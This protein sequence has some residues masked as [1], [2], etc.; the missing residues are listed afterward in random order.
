M[1][2]LKLVV[3]NELGKISMN[4]EELQQALEL[5]LSEYKGIIFTEDSLDIAKKERASLNTLKKDL[6]DRRIAVKK[7]F[8]KPIDDFESNVKKLSIM[9]DEPINQIDKQLDIFEQKRVT[10]KKNEIQSTYNFII[11]EMS[12]FLP[13]EKIYNP[14]WEN[15]TYKLKKIEEEVKSVVVSTV[16]AIETITAMA[17]DCLVQ[18]IEKYKSS[19]NLIDTINFINAYEKQKQ[20]ILIREREKEIER[21]KADERK[22][23]EEENKIR[24]SERIKVTKEVEVAATEKV[25]ESFTP[26]IVDGEVSERYNYVIGLTESEKSTLEMYMDSVGIEYNL[27]F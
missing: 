4:F 21:I 6:S 19:L 1:E 9:I 17:S 22:K 14:K 12:D 20:D 13:L 26:P 10:L 27:T 3:K 24:E 18:A 23:I 2:E 5:K 7:E 16:S 11:G 15:S 25:I 8:M